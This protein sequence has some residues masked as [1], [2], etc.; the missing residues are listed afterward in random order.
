M[1]YHF[2]LIFQKTEHGRPIHACAQVALDHYSE[3]EY[4]N[5]LVIHPCKEAEDFD[6]HIVQ[7][8]DELEEIRRKAREQFAAAPRI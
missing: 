4:G 8:I 1:S 3:D 7:L 2:E 6:S 5:I